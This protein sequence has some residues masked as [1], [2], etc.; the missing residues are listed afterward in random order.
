MI[1]LPMRLRLRLPADRRGETNV[2]L[3]FGPASHFVQGFFDWRGGGYDV[4]G[5]L[6]DEEPIDV[7]WRVACRRVGGRPDHRLRASIEHASIEL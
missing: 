2:R 1:A 5:G 4:T 6:G 3:V 7:A